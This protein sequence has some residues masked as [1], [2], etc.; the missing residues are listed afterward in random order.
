M[1]GDGEAVRPGLRDRLAG[2]GYES[3][4]GH[5]TVG[6][7]TRPAEVGALGPIALAES[8]LPAGHLSVCCP[9]LCGPG[10]RT[11]GLVNSRRTPGAFSGVGHH[12]HGGAESRVASGDGEHG[13]L[14]G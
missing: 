14:D 1:L 6:R 10:E 13:A 9:S 11:G 3:G 4:T 5:G 7:T 12:G 2:H 8:C